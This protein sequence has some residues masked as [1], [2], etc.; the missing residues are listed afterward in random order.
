MRAWRRMA[1]RWWLGLCIGLPSAGFSLGPHEVV[2]LANESSARSIAVA[3]TYARMRDI[4]SV[5]LVRLSLPWKEGQV[6]LRI[7]AEEFTQFIWKP[8]RQEVQSRRLEPQILTWVYSIDFPVAVGTNPTVSLTGLTFLRN[9][10]P[11]HMEADDV[12]YVS[13]LFAGPAFNEMM[14]ESRS[15]D[16]CRD[17][18][19]PAMP[20][21]AMML[22]FAGER[23]NTPDVILAGLERARQADATYPR[24]TVYFVTNSGIRST[25]RQWQ[26]EEVVRELGTL[27][28]RAVITNQIPSGANDLMG[29]MMGAADV[30]PFAPGIVFRPGCMAEHLTSYGAVF[31]DPRQ[32]KI[33]AW[34]SAGASLTAGAVVEPRS[35]WQ[36]FPHARFFAHY[37]RGATGIESLYQSV[38]CPL[39][40]LMLGDPLVAPWKS[41]DG[42]V[43][44]DGLP[45]FIRRD[46]PFTVVPRV[47]KTARNYGRMMYL[48]DGVR[49]GEGL[50]LT[51]PAGALPEGLHTLRVVAYGS[52][53]VCPQVFSE[54]RFQVTGVQPRKEQGK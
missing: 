48:M 51:W 38:R 44:L 8:A 32:T 18:L 28:V 10:M 54:F 24:G 31:D 52:G 37:A 49:V 2:V 36:K 39:Q 16:V 11:T 22:G 45:S 20:L 3:K 34:V 35:I 26:F 19:G 5:N 7:S 27:Q 33:S 47:E 9:H 53:L 17:G 13:P 14:G 40:L 29:V 4:P 30:Q 1:S 15:F 25:C 12:K 6:P 21:P 50:R 41:S 42:R 23:G 46:Q 43:A